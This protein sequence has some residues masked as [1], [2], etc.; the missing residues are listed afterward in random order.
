M[1]PP[2]T[3]GMPRRQRFYLQQFSLLLPAAETWYLRLPGRPFVL[4]LVIALSYCFP[5]SLWVGDSAEPG[6]GGGTPHTEG[7]SVSFRRPRFSIRQSNCS[8]VP[9]GPETIAS[10]GREGKSGARPSPSVANTVQS[11]WRKC[12]RPWGGR[13]GQAGAGAGLKTKQSRPQTR[14]A[15]WVVGAG[16]CR[17]ACSGAW[18]I[19]ILTRA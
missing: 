8:R 14:R 10:R 11:G 6:C 3:V 19:L 17:G 7:P 5:I 1:E 4:V 13:R 12:L 15:V 2:W 18:N 9:L 16:G